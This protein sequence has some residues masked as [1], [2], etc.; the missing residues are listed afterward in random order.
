MI[1]MGGYGKN[2]AAKDTDSTP[3][4]VSEAWHAAR[5]DAAEA[6]DQGVPENRHGD[7]DSGGSGK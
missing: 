6:K 2:D 7:N 3:K 1:K 5:D 4:Q